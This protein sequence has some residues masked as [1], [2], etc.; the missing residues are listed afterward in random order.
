MRTIGPNQVVPL[1]RALDPDS[2]L[3]FHAA[4]LLVL[5]DTCG[6][7][8]RFTRR[9]DG[10]TKLAKLDFFLRYPTFLQRAQ[11][12]LA[13]RSSIHVPYDATG[14]ERE[15]AMI[16]YRF[17]PWDPAYRNYLSFLESRGLLRVVGSNVEGYSLSAA[18]RRLAEALVQTPEFAPIV[19]RAQSMI[20]NLASWSGSELK[21]F[22]YEIFDEEVSS[23]PYRAE[24]TP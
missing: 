12:V 15:S 11:E 17:G 16:R 10:R 2:M 20:G 13:A 6:R 5:I 19:A 24:I 7:T 23:R 22:I 8:G 4:R 14:E 1:H 21:D 18:G 3:E 9:I